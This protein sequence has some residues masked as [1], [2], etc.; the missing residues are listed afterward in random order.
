MAINWC[1]LKSE[2][3]GTACS[4]KELAKKYECHT[5]TINK[6]AS[7]EGWKR[8]RY[9]EIITDH[10][11]LC[12]HGGIVE[13]GDVSAGHRVLWSGVKKRL[14][15]GLN[16]EDLKQGLEELK[17]AKAAGEVLSSVVKGEKLAWGMF[18]SLSTGSCGERIDSERIISEMD[19]LTV[20]SDPEP[21]L[22]SE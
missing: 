10:E 9:E 4:V 13:S 12:Q 7:R 20:S 5:S 17:V 18:D 22:E 11:V 3:T 19:F 6:R 14:I 1:S 2:Y 21:S 15:K 8:F 16:S